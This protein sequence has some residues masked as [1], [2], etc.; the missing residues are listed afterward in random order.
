MHGMAHGVAASSTTGGKHLG[1]LLPG[2]GVSRGGGEVRE[3]GPRGSKLLKAAA[4][5]QRREGEQQPAQPLALAAARR[6]HALDHLGR[7]A[8]RGAEHARDGEG[9]ALRGALGQAARRAEEHVAQQAREDERVL[10]VGE[11]AHLLRVGLRARIRRFGFGLRLAMAAR[12]R[13]RRPPAS[14]RTAPPPRRRTA[15]RPGAGRA[16]ARRAE[17]ARGEVGPVKV[18]VT[19]DGAEAREG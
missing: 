4:V 19:A 3:R 10:R 16:A 12:A 9:A 18:K 8:H 11:G 17:A 1:E 5:G 14:R 7:R 6:V 2:G 13:G 15:A